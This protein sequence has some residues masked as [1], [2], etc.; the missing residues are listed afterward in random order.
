MNVRTRILFAK[1]KRLTPVLASD[2]VRFEDDCDQAGSDMEDHEFEGAI[3]F[4]VLEEGFYV[5]EC[6]REATDWGE[7]GMDVKLADHSIRSATKSDLR[8]FGFLP[9]GD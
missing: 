5:C 7:D 4:E 3:N 8:Y 6:R 1:T 9:D 2:N